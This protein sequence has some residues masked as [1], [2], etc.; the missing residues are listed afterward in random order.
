MR[1]CFVAVKLGDRKLAFSPVTSWPPNRQPNRLTKRRGSKGRCRDPLVGLPPPQ[2]KPSSPAASLRSRLPPATSLQRR[3]PSS[4]L[5]RRLPPS[6]LAITPP[7]LRPPA[8]PPPSVGDLQRRPRDFLWPPV[9]HLLPIPVISYV[10]GLGFRFFCCSSQKATKGNAR[11]GL[12]LVDSENL[13]AGPKPAVTEGAL[14]LTDVLELLT[15]E[16]PKCPHLYIY[17]SADQVIPAKSVESFI[18]RQRRAGHEVRAEHVISCH[19]LT[20]ITSETTEL[21]MIL[22]LLAF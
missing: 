17:S 8:P 1:G 4:D 22:N 9:L 3:L 20:W 18:E 12:N 21:F 11:P 10:A 2:P 16:Q 5:Q 14:R 7:F 6:H 13:C 19:H 15:S